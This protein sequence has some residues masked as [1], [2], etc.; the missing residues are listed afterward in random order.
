MLSINKSRETIE[1]H[2]QK[3]TGEAE[4]TNLSELKSTLVHFYIPI[5]GNATVIAKTM[6][7]KEMRNIPDVH[8]L[9]DNIFIENQQ[10]LEQIYR[11]IISSTRKFFSSMIDSRL[12]N[13]IKHLTSITVILSIPTI[14]SGIYGMNLNPIGMPFSQIANG[15]TAIIIIIILMCLFLIIFLKLKKIL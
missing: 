15:F 6:K 14:I 2:I 11:E 1:K 8:N 9:L 5:K 12:N 7:Y 13:V 4:L 10:N 3:I